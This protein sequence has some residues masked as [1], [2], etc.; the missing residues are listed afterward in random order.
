VEALKK[1]R[2]F[3]E[4]LQKKGERQCDVM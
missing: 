4:E 2:G 3:V 1:Q